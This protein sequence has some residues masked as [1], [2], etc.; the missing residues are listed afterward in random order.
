M[1]VLRNK[2]QLL[3]MTG[4]QRLTYVFNNL[5][6]YF[7]IRHFTIPLGQEDGGEFILHIDW[8]KWG[9]AEV[10]YQHQ[11][12]SNKPVFIGQQKMYKV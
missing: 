1:N 12:L 7:W 8:L 11:N 6:V 2:Q 5:N 3:L 9:K 10:L 4:P